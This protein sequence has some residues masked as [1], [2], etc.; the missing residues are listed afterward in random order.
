MGISVEEVFLYWLVRLLVDFF[1]ATQ[2]HCLFYFIING[3]CTNVYIFYI[4]QNFIMVIELRWN[5]R[6]HITN[7]NDSNKTEKYKCFCCDHF[8]QTYIVDDAS[9]TYSKMLMTNVIYQH[10]KRGTVNYY[11][12][13][14]ENNKTVRYKILIENK[15][16]QI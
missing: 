7:V 3:D 16:V 2:L 9:S 6:K 12:F 13:C 10:I 4:D 1:K 11:W 15:T 14:K 8:H 5:I